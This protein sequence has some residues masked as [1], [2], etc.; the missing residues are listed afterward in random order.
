[1]LFHSLS[2]H[3]RLGN[4]FSLCDESSF[5]TL[6]APHGFQLLGEG[7]KEEKIRHIAHS[8]ESSFSNIPPQ[9]SQDAKLLETSS[10]CWFSVVESQAS[11]TATVPHSHIVHFV[12]RLQ[13]AWCARSFHSAPHCKH[14]IIE[15]LVFT[16]NLCTTANRYLVFLC[17]LK[18]RSLNI[19]SLLISISFYCN[20][21]GPSWSVN[22][23]FQL[24][25]TICHFLFYT[26][27]FVFVLVH[28]Q[29]DDLPYLHSCYLFVFKY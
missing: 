15:F 11:E 22:F 20:S 8:I 10:R 3:S 17:V 12:Q 13:R 9:S 18:F 14:S 19:V 24:F 4:D 25:V 23:I 29:G 28:I 6:C 26:L 27:A 7:R 16:H 2:K 5:G 21:K 1:M